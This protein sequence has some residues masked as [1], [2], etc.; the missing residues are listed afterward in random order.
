MSEG[1]A[2]VSTPTK[3]GS[4]PALSLITGT[5]VIDVDSH[6]MIPSSMWAEAFGDA[7]ADIA[8]LGQ[9]LLGT[10]KNYNNLMR[11][12]LVADDAEI[13]SESVW[14]AK[15]P[16]APG[17]FDIDRRPAVLD[18][19]GIESQLM[20]PTFGLIGLR[21]LSDPAAGKT[22]GVPETMDAADLGRRMVTAYNSWCGAI[23][24]QTR[25]RV[26]P[27]AVLPTNTGLDQ[28]LSTAQGIIDGDIPAVWISGSTP[29][30]DTSPGDQLLDPLWDLFAK[31]NTA[32]T[33][34][35]GT[36]H[37]LLASSKWSNGVPQFVPSTGSTVEFPIEP[38][39]ATTLQLTA[40]NFL[41]ALILGGVFERHPQLR[42]GV[43]ECAAH[44]VGPL[45][46]AMDIWFDEFH[47]RLSPVLS[48][49]P[50]EYLARN[51]RVTPY[52][53]EP[54]DRYLARYP[55]L[56]DVYCYSS[57]YPHMEGGKHSAKVFAD[58]LQN[59][60]EEMREKFFWRNAQ[61]IMPE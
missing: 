25:E 11:D 20:F 23:S 54:I 37:G 43:I 4:R 39:R 41:S 44:W 50:S 15:G 7:G 32:V 31:S 61:W 45:A 19:M 40:I 48:M 26:R 18:A 36:E 33:L 51:V 5:R 59:A 46:E 55:E 2:I 27:V 16:A 17:A 13:T 29:P 35:L 53:F 58:R 6:E 1:D 34:H 52:V 49:R 8:P 30:A 10:V 57:D 60:D 21:F 22:F 3:T 47:K 24:P 56:V 12:D 42:L 28:M 9:G 38:Y 14:T